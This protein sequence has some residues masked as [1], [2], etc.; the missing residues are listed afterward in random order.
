MVGCWVYIWICVSIQASH[1]KIGK[2]QTSITHKK[3]AREDK[4]SLSQNKGL[5]DVWFDKWSSRKLTTVV[6][7][8]PK[9]TQ[10]WG[11]NIFTAEPCFSIPKIYLH[12]SYFHCLWPKMPQKFSNECPCIS[13]RIS[14]T[15][16]LHNISE[17]SFQNTNPTVTSPSLKT[18]Q[19]VCSRHRLTR[20]PMALLGLWL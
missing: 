13:S 5:E 20:N 11:V 7:E 6:L 9:E 19:W 18:S 16:T 14:P 1:F 2:W 12:L 8:Y 15:Q 17:L 4:A 3:Y 10:W